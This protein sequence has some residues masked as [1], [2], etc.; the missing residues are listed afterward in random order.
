M[1]QFLRF[2]NKDKNVIRMVN[3]SNKG[4]DLIILSDDKLKELLEIINYCEEK[5]DTLNILWQMKFKHESFVLYKKCVFSAPMDNFFKTEHCG[6][7]IKVT[8]DN[9][10]FYTDSNIN[11]D[12]KVK[13]VNSTYQD[14]ST[15]TRLLKLTE[16]NLKSK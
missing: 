3:Q 15:L 6:K 13:F 12:R 8:C 11:K 4:F 2:Y 16:L 5:E 10:S 14:M 7:K 9:T 1:K